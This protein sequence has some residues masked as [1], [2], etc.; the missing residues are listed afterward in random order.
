MGFKE[1]CVFGMHQVLGEFTI[2][3]PTLNLMK[4]ES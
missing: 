4:L 2:I 3:E 1:V